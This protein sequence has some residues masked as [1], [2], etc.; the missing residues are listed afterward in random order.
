MIIT[1]EDFNSGLYKIPQ[2]KGLCN[3]DLENY[4]A[5]FEPQIIKE[6]LGCELGQIFLNDYNVGN[7]NM[8][9]LE[10]QLLFDSICQDVKSNSFGCYNGIMKNNGLIDMLK[11]FVFFYYMRD[12]Y[13]KRTLVNVAKVSGKV[14]DNVENSAFGLYN[15][16]NIAVESY[17]VIQYY[18]VENKDVVQYETYNGIDKDFTSYL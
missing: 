3:D 12:F 11:G 18:V 13:N 17:R 5:R 7:K 8:D 4:I 14:S 10:Y 2:S 1:S 16:Y 15:F 9:T 6:L